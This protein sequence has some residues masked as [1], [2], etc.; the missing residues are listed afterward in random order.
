VSPAPGWRRLLRLRLGHHSIERDV[1]DELA[2]HL[3][4]REEKL[5][6]LGV[7]PDMARLGAYDRFGDTA[8]VR[9]EC[10]TID[11]K[12]AREVRL[13]EWLE[14]VWS[15]F[16]YALRTFRRMPTF[17]AVA[18]LTLALGIGATTAMFTLVN[19]ILLRPLPYPESDRI[20]RIIQSYPEKGLDTWGLNQ[21]N[22]AMYRDRSTDFSAFAAYRGGSVTLQG[23]NGPQRIPILRVTSEFF[24]TI[25][26]GPEMGRAFTAEEDSPGKNTVMILSDGTWRSRFGGDPSI[27]G[28]TID[29]DGQPIR[30]VGVMPANFAFPRPDIGAYL[31]MGL[32]PLFRFGFMN[33]GIGRLK[34]GITPEH[35]ERQTTKIM[36]DWARQQSVAKA[37]VDPSKTHMKTIVRPLHEV[38]TGRSARPLTVLL[39]AVVLILL[40]A[41]ANVATLLSGRATARQREITLRA[42]LGASGTRVLRQLLTESVALALLGAVVGVALAVAAVRWFTHSSLATLPRMD[43]VTVDG[44]VLSFTLLVSVAS[45]LLFGLLPAINARRVRLTS[46]LTA[47]QRESSRGA[48]RR[49]NNALVVAQLSLSVVLLIAAGLVLKSFERLTQVDLGFHPEGVTSISLPLPQRIANDAARINTFTNTT[50]SRVRAIPGVQMAA[51]ASAVPMGDGADYDGYLIDGR[52]VPPSGNEDQT[53]RIAVSPDYFKTVG[54]PLLYGRD[55]A[56]TDDSTSLPVAIVDATLANRYW[57]GADALGKRIRTG[58]DT[59]WYTIIG[60]AGT[61]RDGDAALPPEPHLYESIP[62]VGGNPLSLAVRTN[63]SNAGVIRSVRQVLAEANPAIPLDDVKTL[64]GIIDQTYATRRLTKLLLGGFA[65]VALML[66]VVGI[67]GVMS[68]H[69]ANRSR[70]F[71]IRLAIGA[72]P[73]AL[74]RLVLGEGALLAALGVS[75]GIA[76]AIVATRSLASL[77]YE[78]SPTDPVVLLSLPLLLAGIALAA[79]YVPARRAARSDPLSALRAD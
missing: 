8:A 52:P 34:P 29:I 5:R 49:L 74:V 20:V 19:S 70:E 67:Y 32:N 58:G 39:A 78:V 44:R 46:D 37:S 66:A 24:R 3:A 13:M 11:R 50:L 4:M 27:L 65:L 28:R 76:G 71:G 73:R 72:D 2:F 55:F 40:I 23:P 21:M 1:D 54:I 47:G 7:A 15:D 69:V 75:L 48:S 45:G 43:E 9:D 36:W 31:P 26:V 64:N 61:V 14:S 51:L 77:L 63:G 57:K 59:T 62:Q 17:T 6:Q 42:A 35:A 33:A 41:T 25:G 53:Y 79:C 56:V 16:Q 22:I 18:I 38:F 12:Y 60:V 68:L 30:V 10:L